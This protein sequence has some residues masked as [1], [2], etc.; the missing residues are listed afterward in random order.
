MI[1]R[2][3][4][5]ALGAVGLLTLAGCSGGQTTSENAPATGGNAA[6][7]AM[8]AAKDQ[9]NTAA[10]QAGD[11]AKQAADATK[12]AAT[13]A[14]DKAGEMANKAKDTMTGGLSAVKDGVAGLTSVV[15]NTKAAVEA[16]DFAK[17]KEEFGKFEAAWAPIEDGIKSASPEAYTAIED[18]AGKITAAL[19]EASPDKAKVMEMLT[20]LGSSIPGAKP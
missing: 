10:T 7:T 6:T 14:T 15:T 9:A 11:A 1:R 3:Y 17:A 12:D 8:D 18:N 2:N 13:Q 20:S 4:W 19:N 16:G 5:V